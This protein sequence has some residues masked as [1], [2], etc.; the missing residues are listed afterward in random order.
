[1]VRIQR[2]QWRHR[3]VTG[4][5]YQANAQTPFVCGERGEWPMHSGTRRGT[6]GGEKSGE[7]ARRHSRVTRSRNMPSEGGSDLGGGLGVGDAIAEA[8]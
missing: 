7:G 2:R 1:M 4:G 3:S 8:R 6:I 5:A